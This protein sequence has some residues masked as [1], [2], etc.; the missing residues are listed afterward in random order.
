MSQEPATGDAAHWTLA[1]AAERRAGAP[2]GQHSVPL[3]RHG[4]L[5]LK[6]YAPPGTDPQTPHAQDEVYV[7]ARGEGVFFDGES[8]RRCAAGDLLFVVAGRPHRF[9][10]F[11]ADFGV[12]VMFYGPVN[13]ER[14]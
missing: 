2:R 4:T 6:Y 5:L 1:Q 3:F 12:W 14:P 13:G 7:V 10:D 8:R 9:E 11:S